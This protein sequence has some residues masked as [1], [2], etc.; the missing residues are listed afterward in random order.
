MKHLIIVLQLLSI[1]INTSAVYYPNILFYGLM[2]QA[3]ILGLMWID[4]DTQTKK[5]NARRSKFYETLDN[6]TS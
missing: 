1:L 6:A 3:I 2:F 5:I 4:I